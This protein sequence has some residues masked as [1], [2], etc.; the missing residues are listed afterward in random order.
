MGG[1]F[2]KVFAWYDNEW[3]FSNRMRDVASLIGALARLGPRC[4][5][6]RKLE[7]VPVAGKRVFIRADLNVPLRDGNDHRHDAHRRGTAG[8]QVG[9]RQ[10]WASDRRVAP[11]PPEGQTGSRR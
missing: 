6:L 7:E 4:M 2:V 3:G 10:R 5:A 11:R 9:D 8:D 1:N